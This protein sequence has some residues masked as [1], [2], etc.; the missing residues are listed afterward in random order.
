MDGY[1]GSRTNSSKATGPSTLPSFQPFITNVPSALRLIGPDG[2]LLLYQPG[3]TLSVYN[4]NG[5]PRWT[6]GAV[7]SNVAIAPN[8]TVITSSVAPNSVNAY[9]LNTGHQ[10]WPSSFTTGLGGNETGAL[11]IDS[12][13]VVYINTG[14]SFVGVPQ[15]LTAINPDGTLKWQN[16]LA[17]RGFVSP[18]LTHDGSIVKVPTLGFN[19]GSAFG[20]TA[21]FFTASGQ[22]APG[23][24]PGLDSVA[25]WGTVYFT[26]QGIS[27]NSSGLVGCTA[28]GQTC[29]QVGSGSYL[30]VVTFVGAST[31][32]ALGVTSSSPSLIARL[33]AVDSGSGN[34]LWTAAEDLSSVFS[35]ANGTVYAIATQTNDLVALNG[36]TGSQLWRQHFDYPTGALSSP[37]L[38]DDGSVYV[39]AGPTLYKTISPSVGS[40][41]VNSTGGVGLVNGTTSN[42]QAHNGTSTSDIT[43]NNKLRVW[44][45]VNNI[46]S[47]G[48]LTFL[49]PHLAAGVEGVMAKENLIPACKSGLSGRFPYINCQS[50]GAAAWMASFTGPGTIEITLSVTVL[51]AGITLVDW[52]YPGPLDIADQV[53]L[54]QGLENAVPDFKQAMNCISGA[55]RSSNPYSCTTTAI[56]KLIQNDAELQTMTTILQSYGISFSGGLKSELLRLLETPVVL[57]QIVGD[58]TTL[59]VKTGLSGQ[60]NIAVQGK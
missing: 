10:V 60:L 19:F 45:G 27:G 14:A 28:D 44:L 48:A 40:I 22:P 39:I 49:T 29:N 2:S 47:S 58:L 38:G 42:L 51:A 25:P 43:L 4:A 52:I 54:V 6:L 21:G 33:Q 11:A 59:L 24:P 36:L 41:S 32:I 37:L 5:T 20:V 55:A 15:T 34:V 57:A 17:Y 16:T 35:D 23:G 46:S 13:R 1:D 7:V 50:P 3:G 8:G 18:V 53:I 56:N 12:S 31:I 9:D 26:P 30:S